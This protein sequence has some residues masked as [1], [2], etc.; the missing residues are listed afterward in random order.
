MFVK[1]QVKE[2]RQRALYIS[3]ADSC[4]FSTSTPDSISAGILFYLELLSDI[5]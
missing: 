2:L 3:I 1:K 4:S 5:M